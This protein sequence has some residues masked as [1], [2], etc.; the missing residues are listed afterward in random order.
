[1]D[2]HGWHG[3][4]Q[5]LLKL[6]EEMLNFKTKDVGQMDSLSDHWLI[7]LMPLQLFNSYNKMLLDGSQTM[8]VLN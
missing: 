5:D 8:L 1:M 2:I 6:K 7:M 3:L 4:K